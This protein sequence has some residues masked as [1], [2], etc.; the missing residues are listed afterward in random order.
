MPGVIGSTYSGIMAFN[1]IYSEFPEIEQEVS[2]NNVVYLS[3]T[4]NPRCNI[5]STKPIRSLNDLKGLDQG[6]ST[7]AQRGP[8]RMRSR[9][10]PFSFTASSSRA[11]PSTWHRCLRSS[12]A[13]ASVTVDS[14]PTISCA[15][16]AVIGCLVLYLF[17]LQIVKGGEFRQRAKDV[18][19]R[20]TPLP[21]RRGEIFDRNGDDPLAFNVDSFAIDV[22]PG[23]L[24]PAERA[25]LFE[26]LAR[27]LEMVQV[28]V[29]VAAGPDEITDTQVALL[30]EHVGQQ[31]I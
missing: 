10:A 27:L 20:E 3:G 9:R 11:W 21:A 19:Q 15:F 12:G 1:K 25:D 18:S 24:T 16:S 4:G 14:T 29:A 23:D 6:L 8:R 17:W 30:R 28:Q 26:R 22:V 5:I 7:T 13:S 31:C 2:R